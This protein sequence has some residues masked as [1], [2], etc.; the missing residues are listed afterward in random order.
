MKVRD[1]KNE[2]EKSADKNSVNKYLTSVSHWVRR[3]FDSGNG[4][5]TTRD[6]NEIDTLE[7]LAGIGIISLKK[8]S[9]DNIVAE[10]TEEGRELFRDFTGHG[11]YL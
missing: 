2:L 7:T 11:Y 9:G 4:Q 6:F 8:G 5:Y 3:I 10:L 1:L